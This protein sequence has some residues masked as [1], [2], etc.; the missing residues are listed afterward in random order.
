[1]NK[2]TALQKILTI[3]ASPHKMTSK[4]PCFGFPIPT[5]RLHIASPLINSHQK[6]LKKRNLEYKSKIIKIAAFSHNFSNNF[7]S[8]QWHKAGKKGFLHTKKK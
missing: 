8:F 3:T 6:H 4:Q 7:L 2:K 5:P 1:M